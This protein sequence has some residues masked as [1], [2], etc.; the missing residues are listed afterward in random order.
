MT[1]P[2]PTRRSSNPSM[3]T[4]LGAAVDFAPE[5]VISA[6]VQGAAV[7]YME[8]YLWDSPPAKAAF[9][10]AA[11]LAHAAGRQTALTLSDPFLVNRYKDERKEFVEKHVDI[12][13]ANEED[14]SA[15]V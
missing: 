8:G 6:Q 12:V 14:G 9:L 15:D 10:T 11:R 2:F 5:D 13:F 7:T 4:V 1:H 3:N